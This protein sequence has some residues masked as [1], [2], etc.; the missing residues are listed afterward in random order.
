MLVVCENNRIKTIQI[1]KVG[2]ASD[3]EVDASVRVDY[4]GYK[5]ATNFYNYSMIFIL[6]I[7]NKSFNN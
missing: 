1:I 2:I 5:Y 4:L 6:H 7:K 3:V